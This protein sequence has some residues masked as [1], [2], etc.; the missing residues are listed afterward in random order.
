MTSRLTTRSVIANGCKIFAV[1]LHIDS[2]VAVLAS[3]NGEFHRSV[4]RHRDRTA[5]DTVLTAVVVGVIYHHTCGQLTAFRQQH[6]VRIVTE[7]DLEVHKCASNILLEFDL[8]QYAFR[9]GFTLDI[10][11][12]SFCRQVNRSRHTEFHIFCVSYF[13]TLD[14]VGI[15]CFRSV[16]HRNGIRSLRF[17]VSE[18][19]FQFACYSRLLEIGPAAAVQFYA[20]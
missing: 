15:C 1:L 20:V 5:I 4:N 8:A 17:A 12:R 14:R 19:Q 18:R 6:R 16:V 9:T 10:D 13:R 3:T 7:L 2:R 11:T